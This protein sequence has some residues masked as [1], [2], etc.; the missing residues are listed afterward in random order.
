MSDTQ[1]NQSQT[2][3]TPQLKGGWKKP[4]TP[5]SWKIPQQQTETETG[6][7]KKLPAFAPDLAE[8][9]ATEGEWHRP[10]PE[11]TIYDSDD[12]IEIGTTGT[13][14]PVRP[15]DVLFPATTD[16]EETADAAVA[17]EDTPTDFTE[18]LEASTGFSELVMQLMDQV[19]DEP[20]PDIML[21]VL[22]EA[23]EEDTAEATEVAD[24]SEELEFTGATDAARAA[25]SQAALEEAADS[26][27]DQSTEVH[28]EDYARRQLDELLTEAD[29]PDE[30]DT[31]P[32]T[33]AESYAQQR[34]AEL[35]GDDEAQIPTVI[36]D[37]PPAA[38][39]EA[40]D[41][42]RQQVDELAGSG[43]SVSTVDPAEAELTARFAETQAKVRALRQQQRNGL[44]TRDQL[45]EQLRE[46]LILDNENQWWMMGV[47]SDVW[48]RY[49]NALSDWVTD[50]PPV[51]LSAPAAPPTDTSNIDPSNV[52][53][54]SLPY[55]EDEPASPTEYT[56]DT[57]FSGEATQRFPFDSSQPLPRPAPI[58][59]FDATVVSPSAANLDE[60]RP[61][62]AVTIPGLDYGATVVNPAVNVDDALQD[63]DAA[64]P[65]VD[66]LS[67]GTEAYAEAVERRQQSTR[68]RLFL[69]ATLV[70]G[71]FFAV[72]ALLLVVVVISYNN[73]ANQFRDEVL[74]LANYQAQF[75]TVRI[76]DVN[77]DPL[78]ELNNEASGGTRESIQSLNEVSPDAIYAIVGAQ[79]PRFFET[80]GFDPGAIL[81]AFVANVQGQQVLDADNL[82]I[83]QQIA[84][85]FVIDASDNA[86]PLDT[87]VVAS[88]IAQAHSK[89][90]ILRLYLNEQSFGNQTFGIQAAADFYFEKEASE[91][92]LT[93]GSLLAAM[94]R[95]PSLDPV[96]S[97]VRDLA[98]GAADNVLRDLAVVGCL[99]FEHPAVPNGRYCKTSAD[100]LRANNNFS[101]DI[102]IQRAEMQTLPF[103][104]R[105][106]DGLYPHFVAFVRAQLAGAYGEERMFQDGFVVQTT[107]DPAIQEVAQDNLRAKLNEQA[108][109]GLQTGAVMVMNP[110]TGA[111]MAM[112][113]SPDYDNLDLDGQTNQALTWHLPGATML[114]L[115]YTAALEGFDFNANGQRDFNEYLTPATILFDLPPEF[116]NPNFQTTNS[117]NAFNGP[118]SLREALANNYAPAAVNVYDFVGRE[119]LIPYL[120]QLGINFRSDPPEVTHATA[121]GDQTA[122]RLRDLMQAYS[123]LASSGQYVPLRTIASVE[124]A[125]GDP[126]ELPEALSPSSP[127]QVVTPQIAFLTQNIL[128]NQS[129]YEDRFQS[130]FMSS[131][132]DRLGVKMNFL[133]DNRDMWAIGFSRNAV[134]GVWMGRIDAESTIANSRDA[135]LPVWRA[136]ME[137]VLAGTNP[138]PYDR[139]GVTF[140]PEGSLRTEIICRTTGVA[141]SANCAQQ[142]SEI[143]ST[144]HPPQDASQMPVVQAVI[145]TWTRLLV[146]DA[147]RTNTTQAAFARFVPRDPG[148][149]A[150]LNT[151]TGQGVAR[152]MGLP[153][154]VQ[155]VPTTACPL[156]TDIPSLQFTGP[157]EGSAVQGTVQITGV[158]SATNFGSYQLEY[159]PVGTENYQPIT[160][161]VNT[162]RA[163]DN[164]ILADWNTVG[165][166]NGQY[167]LRLT[168]RSANR[169]GIVRRTMTLSVVNPTP[170]AL[171]PTA[172]LPP[173]ATQTA[174]PIFPTSTPIPEGGPTATIVIG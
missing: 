102:T 141:N 79:D 68:T 83:T 6:G 110:Q 69:L 107:L 33:N 12:Q 128:S 105:S 2:D 7:W 122:V 144:S 41:Y 134:V 119:R 71:G 111:V 18:S 75:Q 14:T 78:A 15:E 9:P 73:R 58:N 36:D 143:F 43:E 157:I 150:W 19:N 91:L 98:F 51:Q 145:D 104:P 148:A 67:Q 74:A 172:T 44:I 52:I 173:A 160:G 50:T 54:G 114:P 121:V 90:F 24:D 170:T 174:V 1:P 28:P 93:E 117:N 16:E 162:P 112:V 30:A 60:M 136:V 167:T 49:D 126:V 151:T 108:T 147:C 149:I 59:D 142:G 92:N 94:L 84:E 116:Q 140:I 120:Q 76:L 89:E 169:L 163:G 22:E 37:S 64:P 129:F 10:R 124:T 115:L 130:M 86:T 29:S 146:S 40:A 11:D 77:G 27:G 61:S 152:T 127:Q 32:D 125:S 103:R 5:G 166:A 100:I 63:V 154:P 161:E 25:L 35:L 4:E 164:N 158:A 56:E 39:G 171:P 132:P 123:V 45:Q 80:S 81:S 48:Y 8:E 88:E 137:T 113:G 87:F 47:E 109:F 3:D 66:D 70:V 65:N 57:A 165:V 106:G 135:A 99:N 139:P 96:Q 26:I 21:E 133:D 156:N 55:L 53:E 131:F 38:T 101:A 46:H 82:T 138:I 97:G 155:E 31:E 153:I 85:T 159:A 20:K 17:P 23:V 34:L 42:A 118:V 72:L 95:D 168:M 13:V 62:E